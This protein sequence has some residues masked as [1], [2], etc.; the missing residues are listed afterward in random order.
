MSLRVCEGGGE[1][2]GC[3]VEEERGDLFGEGVRNG[4]RD[5][6]DDLL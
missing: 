1:E 4:G 6:V 3:V 5:G 2:G